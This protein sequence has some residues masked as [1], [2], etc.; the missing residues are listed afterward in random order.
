MDLDAQSM[1]RPQK[2]YRCL[3]FQAMRST[4]CAILFQKILS[5]YYDRYNTNTILNTLVLL[6]VVDIIL[7]GISVIVIH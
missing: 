5:L 4:V 7:D 2:I 1:L 3:L 6:L